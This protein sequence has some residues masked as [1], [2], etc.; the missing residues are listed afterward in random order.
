[1]PEITSSVRHVQEINVL[2]Q[3]NDKHYRNSKSH[4]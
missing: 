4:S 1:M 2:L 3:P